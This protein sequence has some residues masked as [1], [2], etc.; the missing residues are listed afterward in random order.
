VADLCSPKERSKAVDASCCDSKETNKE[1]R[2]AVRVLWI[3][4]QV[5][6]GC[7]ERRIGLFREGVMRLRRLGGQHS[8]ID[9]KIR[10]HETKEGTKNKK[11]KLLVQKAGGW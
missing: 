3:E 9:T 8:S 1:K 7:V 4:Y 6:V 11:E 5:T 2:N 10:A